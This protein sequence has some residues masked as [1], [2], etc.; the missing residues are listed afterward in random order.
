MAQQ[1]EIHVNKE[2]NIN[3]V[4]KKLSDHYDN[5]RYKHIAIG[6]IFLLFGVIISLSPF[7]GGLGL[8]AIILVLIMGL[9]FI[10][11]SLFQPPSHEHPIILAIQFNPEKITAF[12][13]KDFKRDIKLFH[14]T[15]GVQ[16]ETRLVVQYLG[17]KKYR[18]PVKEDWFEI[19]EFFKLK[20]PH[21]YIIQ[22]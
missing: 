6:L 10:A 3:P 4:I 9:P 15:W 19:N 13:L 12:Y 17:K 2:I 7:S 14:I 16:K 21:A 5:E 18:F 22:N 11:I 1:E 20:C 8:Y